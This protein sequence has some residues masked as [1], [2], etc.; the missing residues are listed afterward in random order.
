MASSAAP[1][2][3]WTTEA[4]SPKVLKGG[5]PLDY[6]YLWWPGTS[7]VA[8]RDHAFQAE[9]INGQ[10]IYINP[11]LCT[12]L[13]EARPE[14]VFGKPIVTYCPGELRQQ[15]RDLREELAGG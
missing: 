8:R 12:I 3:S 15:V 5:D 7:P 10:F 2:A 9:G 1:V 13:G 11:T 4:T 6:G 14:D